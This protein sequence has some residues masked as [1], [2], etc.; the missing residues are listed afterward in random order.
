MN[1]AFTLIEVIIAISV[2]LIGILGVYAVIPRIISIS[3]TNISRFIASQL[4]REGIEIV[5][6][7]RDSNA[8][9]GNDFDDGL[10]NGDWRV[11][12]NRDF[13]L[14]FAEIP[15][16]IDG[17]GFYNYDSGSL[18]NFKRKVILS[19]PGTDNL[20]VKVEVSWPGEGSPLVVEEILYNWR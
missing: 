5:R 4:G 2:F 20:N 12:Y 15:L 16:K 6:N 14:S 19:H 9:K 13:L 8:L 17:N 7:I 18:T 1:K 11:Q 3:S 10:N